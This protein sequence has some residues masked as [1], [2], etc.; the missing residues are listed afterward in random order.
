MEGKSMER[1]VG[2]S[3]LLQMMR[4]RVFEVEE[5]YY[6]YLNEIE[7]KLL[8]Y[9]T[10]SIGEWEGIFKE[11]NLSQDEYENFKKIWIEGYVRYYF[12][13]KAL[14]DLPNTTDINTVRRIVTVD[15]LAYPEILKMKLAY[16]YGNK[17]QEYES[18]VERWTSDKYVMQW[19]KYETYRKLDD[20]WDILFAS[21]K[22]VF[23]SVLKYK[24]GSLEGLDP[25]KFILRGVNTIDDLENML[26]FTLY[27]YNDMILPRTDLD[28]IK[29]EYINYSKGKPTQ[30]YLSE[31]FKLIDPG[32]N[33]FNIYSLEVMLELCIVRKELAGEEELTDDDIDHVEY[34]LDG[35]REYTEAINGRIVV[36]NC[37]KE[38][39]A[40]KGNIFQGSTG[41][42]VNKRY[43]LYAMRHNERLPK[44]IVSEFA[45]TTIEEFTQEEF[46]RFVQETWSGYRLHTMELW[47]QALI[48]GYYIPKHIRQELGDFCNTDELLMTLEV[49][50]LSDDD[51]FKTMVYYYMT[52]TRYW[53]NLHSI[54]T[55]YILNNGYMITWYE[56]LDD[57]VSEY[58]IF[59]SH[60]ISGRGFLS[61]S[62]QVDDEE[63][64]RY[65]ISNTRYSFYVCMDEEKF[66]LLANFRVYLESRLYG[67][68]I[69]LEEARDLLQDYPEYIL[70]AFDALVSSW[71]LKVSRESI[72][73]LLDLCLVY[74]LNYVKDGT[75]LLKRGEVLRLKDEHLKSLTK[76]TKI[77]NT[78][79]SDIFFGKA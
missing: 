5:E 56:L 6:L 44:K 41:L 60:R 24:R 77:S 22:S 39:D 19:L 36:D 66:R 23:D 25:T 29:W 32:M 27:C 43:L 61:H 45:K 33:T 78:K 8:K 7:D 35:M 49:N 51:F 34:V 28:T 48:C 52:T 67:D 42:S 74:Y 11:S 26:R 53:R 13:R 46:T 70:V 4:N 69:T 65:L 62:L 58:S 73:F 40:I 17:I 76:K 1:T 15:D 3:L 12:F 54:I 68:L 9:E 14:K 79:A 2:T 20:Y 21:D 18:I 57:K 72:D 47:F 75:N 63:Y 50:D 16:V 59:L 38:K 71:D 37:F 31:L 55:K 10:V 64:N 30:G